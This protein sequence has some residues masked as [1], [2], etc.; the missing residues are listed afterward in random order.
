MSNEQSKL[1]ITDFRLIL[2]GLDQCEKDMLT[3]R[4]LADGEST[5][6]EENTSALRQIFSLFIDR[7]VL[8]YMLIYLCVITSSYSLNILLPVITE[9]LSPKNA[10]TELLTTSSF[11]F[12]L[13]S[14]V[15][16]V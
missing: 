8:L 14:L 12:L 16:S 10:T 1:S 5:E 15:F 2:G 4:L 7:K 9:D 6:D 13:K 11:C 3:T